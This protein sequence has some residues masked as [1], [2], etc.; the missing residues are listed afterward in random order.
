MWRQPNQ[1]RWLEAIASLDQ[2]FQQGEISEP[3]YRS[4]REE[5]KRSLLKIALRE[6]RGV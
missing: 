1:R 5:L 6:A 4:Q 2:R 3:D